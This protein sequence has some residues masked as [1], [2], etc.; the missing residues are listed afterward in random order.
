MCPSHSRSDC[1]EVGKGSFFL[2]LGKE[3]NVEK[4]LGWAGITET[5]LFCPT[6]VFLE[7]SKILLY[8]TKCKILHEYTGKFRSKSSD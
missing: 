4:K 1:T 3:G 2:D 7:H 8:G 6:L 5:F